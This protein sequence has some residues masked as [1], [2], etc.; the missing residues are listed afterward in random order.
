MNDDLQLWSPWTIAEVVSEWVDVAGMRLHR[1]GVVAVRNNSTPAIGSAAGEQPSDAR[2]RFELL[3]R[4]AVVDAMANAEALFPIR[5][6]D[7][8]IQGERASSEL[9][10]RSGAE[11]WEYARS[12]G[13]A[14]GSSWAHACQHARLE[15]VERHAVLRCWYGDTALNPF[16]QTVRNSRADIYDWQFASVPHAGAESVVVCIAFP[17]QPTM[18]LLRG[19]AADSTRDQAAARA[20]GECLQGLVFLFEEPIPDEAPAVA[21][22]PGYHLDLYL[23]PPNHSRL[24][25][26]MAGE[27]R[28]EVDVPHRDSGRA[29]AVTYVDITPPALRD[30]NLWV[31]RAIHEEMEPLV[32]GDGPPW[33]PSI[34]REHPIS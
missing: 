11:R 21:T 5:D 4:M 26:W 25:R 18:P 30:Q 10:P 29:G 33:V 27:R 34:G 16:E 3:E 15:L 12:N 7:G 31:A 19:F 20:M 6:L 17:L 24:H 22:H 14:I 32:F 1:A 8:T 28:V 9:F 13:V 23:W 2:A